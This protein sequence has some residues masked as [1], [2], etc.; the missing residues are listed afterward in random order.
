MKFLFA[1]FAGFG[2]AAAVINFNE[3]IRD[4]DTKGWFVGLGLLAF[5]GFTYWASVS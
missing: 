1:I 3:I 4:P 5:V 2:L